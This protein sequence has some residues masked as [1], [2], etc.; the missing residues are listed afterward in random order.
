MTKFQNKLE[1][2]F[3]NNTSDTGSLN[4]IDSITETLGNTYIILN[5]L[6]QMQYQLQLVSD[7]VRS[8]TK[9][10]LLVDEINYCL[11]GLSVNLNTMTS[12]NLQISNVLPEKVCG[13]LEKFRLI[14]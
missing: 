12:I 2:T 5:N 14:L 10:F 11:E 4:P 6:K 13:D 7:T 9:D 3:K 8:D 1:I